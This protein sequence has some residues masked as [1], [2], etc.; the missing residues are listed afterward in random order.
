VVEIGPH[1]RVLYL[2]SGVRTPD[3]AGERLEFV[4]ITTT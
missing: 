3:Q 2:E 1:R 4:R